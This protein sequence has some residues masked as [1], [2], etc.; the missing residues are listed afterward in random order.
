[1][2]DITEAAV[3]RAVK[4]ELRDVSSAV[5]QL[6]SS[7]SSLRSE[8][9]SIQSTQSDIYRSLRNVEQRLQSSKGLSE[10]HQTI[11]NIQDIVGDM[12]ARMANTEKAVL[13]TTA[14]VTERVREREG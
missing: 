3:K 5:S 2:A 1:M 11:V 14:Y 13:Y 7:L 9:S 12:R 8:L 6:K 4:D 10:D